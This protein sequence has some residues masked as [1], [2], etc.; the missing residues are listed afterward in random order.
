MNNTIKKLTEKAGFCFWEDEPWGSGP[1]HI[2]WGPEYSREFVRFITLLAEH[3]ERECAQLQAQNG[4][5]FSDDY[6]A[7]RRM[8]MEV[9][10]N[11]LVADL[12]LGGQHETD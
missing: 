1:G 4:I 7:G 12:T 6:A 9:L 11:T 3:I 10:K 5:N 8:G 2:D